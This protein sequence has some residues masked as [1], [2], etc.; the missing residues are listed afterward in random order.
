MKKPTTQ[1]ETPSGEEIGRGIAGS[2][3]NLKGFRAGDQAGKTYIA[4]P[5][6]YKVIPG[7]SIPVVQSVVVEAKDL[8]LEM[9]GD[10][11]KRPELSTVIVGGVRAAASKRFV[12]SMCGLI[13]QS[14][15]V[16]DIF[17]PEEVLQRV[18]EKKQRDQYR[19][20]FVETLDGALETVAVVAPDK[21]SI[22]SEEIVRN[23]AGQ[24]DLMN[25]AYDDGTIT[26]IH[27]PVQANDFIIGSDAMMAKF[28]VS[29]PL[30]SY[31]SVNSYMAIIR[32][33]CIN[34]NIWYNSAFKTSLKLGDE[35]QG[36][37]FGRFISTL[38]NE[39]GFAAISNRMD[40]AR[41]THAS[42]AE[43]SEIRNAMAAAA[44]A[45][46]NADTGFAFMDAFRSMIRGGDEARSLNETYGVANF[47]ELPM[48]TLQRLQ[49]KCS[50]YD[51]MNFATE[52]G[53]HHVATE[54]SRRII[55]SATTS[56]MASKGG[57]DLEG[58]APYK[59]DTTRG[60]W[61]A[62]E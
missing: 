5:H 40:A 33:I 41:T 28:I 38:N 55:N 45:F 3:G 2:E 61:L 6:K 46:D 48:K 49:S 39:E 11:G 22:G 29:T 58:V 17:T 60:L 18:I 31:G 47:S 43:V 27:D 54:K 59:H 62:A 8:Q 10:E 51:L 32:L 56:V 37:A 36:K 26:T 20:Q 35:E 12:N 21:V 1:S 24:T 15:S 16:F 30:D 34:L 53:T 42:I 14:K 13:G 7:T 44:G 23:L 9:S 19:I 25:I 50:V 52:F 57:L 4:S